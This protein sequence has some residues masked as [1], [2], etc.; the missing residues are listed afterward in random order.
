VH[1]RLGVLASTL[2]LAVGLS[3]APAAA[4]GTTDVSTRTNQVSALRLLRD[5]PVAPG[6]RAGYERA[7]FATWMPRSPLLV[8][9]RYLSLTCENTV[10][11]EGFEPPTPG[12]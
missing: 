8:M 11:A 7:K 6:S 1:L 10:G 12:M 3:T 2:A 5:L 9:R 4:I